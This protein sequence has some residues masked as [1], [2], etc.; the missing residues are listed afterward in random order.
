MIGGFLGAGKSTLLQALLVA[1]QARRIAVLVNDFGEINLDALL[2]AQGGSGIAAGDHT[3][4]IAL[5]NG[6]VCCTIGDDLTAA[7]GSVLTAT[8]AFDAVVV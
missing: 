5:S 6:C 4:T 3:R 2:L 8:P 7:L 1:S